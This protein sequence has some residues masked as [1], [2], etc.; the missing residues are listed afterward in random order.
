MSQ[1]MCAKND[2]GAYCVGQPVTST[3]SG[4]SLQQILQY[5]SSPISALRRRTDTLAVAPNMTTFADSNIAFMLIDPS[6]PST[7]LCGACTRNIL[8]SYINFESNVLYTPGL[9]Q[10]Q[11][12][13]GQTELYTAVQ[14]TCGANFMSGAVQAAGGLSGGTFSSGAL[15]VGADLQ[16]IVGLVTGAFIL[17]VSSAL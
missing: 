8:T 2:N 13:K 16:K 1:A 5:I 15:A 4:L 17:A 7:S 10:S 9:P 6:L 3:S 11:I 14:G 12:L